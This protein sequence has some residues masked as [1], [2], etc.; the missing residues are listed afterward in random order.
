MG[1]SFVFTL[2]DRVKLILSGE[3]GSVIGRAE[4][5]D[6]INQ[7]RVRYLAA[8]GRQVEDWFAEDAIV[9]NP[10]VGVA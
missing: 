1:P 2:G 5:S 10:V 9:G 6:T 8:D 4:Y 7:Y 3:Q